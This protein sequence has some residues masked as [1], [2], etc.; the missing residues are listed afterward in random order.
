MIP[1][2]GAAFASAFGDHRRRERGAHHPGSLE[3][4]ARRALDAV[5]RGGSDLYG[6]AVEGGADWLRHAAELGDIYTRG[7]AAQVAATGSYWEPG[8]GDGAWVSV[9]EGVRGD[10]ARMNP[11]A[12]SVT[13]APVV[14]AMRR[15]S[16]HVLPRDP[17]KIDQALQRVGRAAPTVAAT[18]VH[19]AVGAVAAG[20]DGYGAAYEDA[21]AHGADEA[22]AETA[23]ARN[24]VVQAGLAATPIPIA[25]A[26]EP[27]IARLANPLA[28]GAA[29]IVLRGGAGGLLRRRKP[30]RLQR[31]GSRKLR[32]RE[33]LEPRR[34]HKRA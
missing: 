22:G 13:T 32:P 16:R 5:V 2:P 9:P 25:R 33:A 26:A 20:I 12:V 10:F 11:H 23:G 18:L 7:M 24:M 31:G 1:Q 8:P 3:R 17:T 30:S 15:H 4:E 34:R 29:R 14:E 27:Y 28:R 19:P 6:G 21:L